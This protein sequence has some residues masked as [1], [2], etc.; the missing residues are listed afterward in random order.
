MADDSF[1]GHARTHTHT[2]T[3]THTPTRLLTHAQQLNTQCILRGNNAV[4]HGCLFMTRPI[5]HM[6]ATE[7]RKKQGWGQNEA[8]W[9]QCRYVKKKHRSKSNELRTSSSSSSPS[10]GYGSSRSTSSWSSRAI[11]FSTQCMLKSTVA[12]TNTATQVVTPY[13][14]WLIL[15]ITSRI[16]LGCNWLKHTT[17]PFCHRWHPL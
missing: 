5:L 2:N 10:T 16:L 9:W 13:G 14:S 7:L 1:T 12:C 3:Q 4:M 15:F 8:V 11:V 17:H 6:Q